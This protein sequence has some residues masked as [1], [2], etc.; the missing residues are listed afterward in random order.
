MPSNTLV[1]KI[2]KSLASGKGIIDAASGNWIISP[3]NAKK[4]SKII[5]VAD[6][7]VVGVFQVLESVTIP[8]GKDAGRIRFKLIDSP[9]EELSPYV[10]MEPFTFNASCKYI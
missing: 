1:V 5:A 4:I 10:S 3:S 2:D 8:S 9:T 6:K 7:K